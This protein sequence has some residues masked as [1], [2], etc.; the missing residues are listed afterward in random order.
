MQKMSRK[1]LFVSM[2]LFS[3]LNSM[4]RT[5]TN[6]STN[7]PSCWI[8]LPHSLS[9]DAKAYGEEGATAHYQLMSDIA[10][11]KMGIKKK[12]TVKKMN[13]RTEHA[14]GFGSIFI[15]PWVNALWIN[16]R[17]CNQKPDYINLYEFLHEFAHLA[18]Y[19][20]VKR[21]MESYSGLGLGLVGTCNLVAARLP[22]FSLPTKFR[23][24]KIGA[25]TTFSSLAKCMVDQTPFYQSLL[26]KWYKSQEND[27]HRKALSVHEDPEDVVEYYKSLVNK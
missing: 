25:V 27:A 23:L 10:R 6:K 18:L 16:Q 19:H 13:S 5:I 1:I 3:S 21:G 8:D 22:F 26:Q 11:N 15:I 2:I 9:A 7:S 24:L 12:F 17:L 14:L 20:H 4:E